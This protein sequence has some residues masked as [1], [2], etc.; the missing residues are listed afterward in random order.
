M[1]DFLKWYLLI[2]ILGWLTFPIAFRFFPN[3]K[4]RGFRIFESPR[5]ITLGVCFLAFWIISNSTKRSCRT[6][7]CVV[8]CYADCSVFFTIRNWTAI[9]AWVKA[10]Y[11]HDPISRRGFPGAVRRL[12][13]RPRSQPGCGRHRKTNGTGVYQC[14]PAIPFLSPQRSMAFGLRDL[15]LLFRVCDHRDAGED[16]WCGIRCGI[17]PGSCQLVCA[18]RPW[19]LRLD[20]QF[21]IRLATCS[22]RESTVANYFWSLLG[23]FLPVDREQC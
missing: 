1:V 10:E 6:N 5:V 8:D 21:I 19:R 14:H 16:N 22:Q 23:P 9:K 11:R 4:D 13:A 2:T 3:L 15:L 18:C 17:Q 12:G 20:P 7:G